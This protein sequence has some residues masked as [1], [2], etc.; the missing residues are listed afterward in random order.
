[1]EKF[2]D[3]D[4]KRYMEHARIDGRPIRNAIRWAKEQAKK[5]YAKKI[6]KGKKV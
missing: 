1:M 2:E 4:F 3:K 5:E 6:A